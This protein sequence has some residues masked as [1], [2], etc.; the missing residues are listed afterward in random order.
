MSN[1][2]IRTDFADVKPGSLYE[3]PAPLPFRT[4]GGFGTQASDQKVSGNSDLIRH[5]LSLDEAP[6]TFLSD[7]VVLP[8]ERLL[9]LGD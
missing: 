8:A 1:E 6:S 9:I 4:R 2:P 5:F 3:N 7:Y